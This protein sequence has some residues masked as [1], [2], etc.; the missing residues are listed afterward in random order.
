MGNFEAEKRKNKSY[1]NGSQSRLKL[2]IL[3]IFSTYL[4]ANFLSKKERGE[5]LKITN[6]L[7]R[8]Y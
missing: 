3:N 1:T 7:A 8:F 5:F 2:V 4:F 6:F